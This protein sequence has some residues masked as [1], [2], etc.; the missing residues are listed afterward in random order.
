MN[1]IRDATDMAARLRL[2]L[3]PLTR[4]LRQQNGPDLTATQASALASISRA[5]PLTVGELAEIEHVSSPMITKVAKHLEE[6]GLVTRSDDPADRRVTRLAVTE[7]G[8]R[9]LE[10]SRNRKNAWLATRL[11][12]LEAGEL[13]AV[14]AAIPVLERLTDA[15]AGL[16]SMDAGT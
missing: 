15:E 4:T 8:S 9:R 6:L 5:G 13:A 11:R 1:E 7:E 16:P 10:A 12:A 14:E 3:V 2:A